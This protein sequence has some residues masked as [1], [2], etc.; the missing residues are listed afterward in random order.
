MTEPRQ[1][2]LD[3]LLTADAANFAYPPTPEDGGKAGLPLVY[4]TPDLPTSIKD[5][6]EINS[7]TV[8]PSA[9]TSAC[10]RLRSAWI[11][12]LAHDYFSFCDIHFS[13]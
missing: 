2:W 1:D 10:S 11:M 8:L 6:A 12:H 9:P 4:S 5:F 7:W 3:E 13:C